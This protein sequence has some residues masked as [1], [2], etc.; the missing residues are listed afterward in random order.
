MDTYPDRNGNNPQLRYVDQS[1]QPGDGG[2]G[3]LMEV[4]GFKRLPRAQV[5]GSANYLAN[6]RDTNGT[7]S[8]AINRLPPNT[9]PTWN[10]GRFYN[11]VPDQ[12]M[13]R[14]GAAVPIGQ[15]GF[16]AS[17]AWRT[18]I[19]SR[20]RTPAR[21]VTP[22]SRITFFLHRTDI[23]SARKEEATRQFVRSPNIVRAKTSEL[24]GCRGNECRTFFPG[25][26][27]ASLLE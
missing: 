9:Q 3:I 6:P 25:I 14:L 1:V 18:E 20:I 21:L 16:A 5:F 15:T 12:F 2:W 23:D 11:S 24:L 17:L 27:A 26:H 13:A 22:R 19:V 8:G 7:T 10:P 4:A